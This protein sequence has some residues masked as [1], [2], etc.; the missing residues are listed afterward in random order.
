MVPSAKSYLTDLYVTNHP[1]EFSF[2][3]D[4]SYGG[5]T[6]GEWLRTRMA[7]SPELTPA[8]KDAIR[9]LGTN[10]IPALLKRLAYARPSYCFSQTQIY[11]DAAGGFITLGEQAEPAFPTLLKFMDGTNRDSA[12]FSMIATYGTGSNAI[13]V[14]IKGLTNQITDV[15]NE[16]A[17]CLFE[18]FSKKFPEQCKPAVPFLVKLVNDPD[19]D[20]R[21]N[22]TNGLK[23]IDPL[24]A[25]RA[26][27]K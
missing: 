16:A 10:A 13:P 25:A 9:H 2:P 5:K 20:V 4:P 1:N 21:M 27:I 24:A 14:F 7:D 15:R 26:G 18:E 19:E 11:T 23:Q 8:A 22:A 17:D 3:N 12:L 6:L